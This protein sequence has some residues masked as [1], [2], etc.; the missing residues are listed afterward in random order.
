LGAFLKTFFLFIFLFSS[1]VSLPGFASEIDARESPIMVS[2]LQHA[3]A[4]VY[5]GANQES[6]VVAKQMSCLRITPTTGSVST[7]CDFIDGA[8][9]QTFP[10]Y[11]SA[12]TIFDLTAAFGGTLKEW[13]QNGSDYKQITANQIYCS[14]Q[15]G[16]NEGWLCD[17]E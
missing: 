9:G 3:G 4:Q 12:D 13:T 11:T 5:S 2:A 14:K 17:V 8:S 15:A 10:A 7:E 6:L 16:E 1:F